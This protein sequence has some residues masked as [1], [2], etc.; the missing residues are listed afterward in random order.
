MYTT[1]EK[2]LICALQDVM[3]FIKHALCFWHIDKNFL[4][5]CKLLFDIEDTWPEFHN[6]WY[7]VLY[8]T[9]KPTLEEKWVEFLVKYKTDYWI[10]IDYL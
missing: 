5:N 2:A 8:C 3:P 6:D 10:A 7:W 9:T 1:S 4:I